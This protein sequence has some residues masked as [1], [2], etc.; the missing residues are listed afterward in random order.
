V[1]TTEQARTKP[2]L[3]PSAPVHSNLLQLKC[4]CG[5]APGVDGM[6][7]ECREKQLQ[8]NAFGEVERDPASNSARESLHSPGEPPDPETRALMGPRSGHDFSRIQVHSP[9]PTGIQP[10]LQVSTPNDRYEQEANRVADQ[11]IRMLAPPQRQLQPAEEEDL[12]ES[13]STVQRRAAG[14]TGGGEAPPIIQEVLSSPG[15]PLDPSTRQFME[16]RFGHDFSQ[17]RVHADKRA[18][19]SAQAVNAR[20]YAVGRNVVFGQGEYVPGNSESQS[21]LA[22]EL[23]HIALNH[24]GVRCI[25]DWQIEAQEEARERRRREREA[26]ARRHAEWEA[27]VGRQFGPELSS[28]ALTI[29][30]ERERLGLALT[31]QRAAAFD[32]VASGQGWLQIAL[33]EQG[34]SG[35][36]VLE[37]KER[38]AEALVAAELLRASSSADEVTTDVRIHALETIPA[39][40]RDIGILA[41]A[42]EQAH[43]AH[44]QS[45]NDKLSIQYERQ[46]E[47][48]EAGQRMDRMAYGPRGEPGEAAFRA[49]LAL[50][51]GSPPAEPKYLSEPPAISGSIPAASARVDTAETIADWTKVA[52]DLRR[53]DA[54]L[55]E[56]LVASLE[57]SSEV[58]QNIEYLTQLEGRLT[59]L[60]GK[61]PVA[62]RIPAVFYPEDQ[63]T[64]QTTAEGQ[65]QTRP[66]SIPWQFYLINTGVPTRDQPARSGGEWILKDLTSSQGFENKAPASDRDSAMLQQGAV[67]DPPI[68][69]F[70]KLN[71]RIRF[72]NGRIYFTLPSGQSYVLRTTEPWSLS[73]FLAAMGITLAAIAITA[74]VVATGGAAAPAAIAFYAGLG[75]AAAGA[76]STLAEMNERRQHGILTSADVDRAMIQIGIDLVGALSLGLGRLVTAPGAIARFGS[77]F[78]V[79]SRV[80]QAARVANV[81]GDVYQTLTVTDS[82]LDAFNA[83]ENQ[84]GLTDEQRDRM[85]GQLVRRAI[86]TGAILTVAI[87]GDIDEI[88][89][90]QTLRVSSVDPDGAIVVHGRGTA[91][92]GEADAPRARASP[93][94]PGPGRAPHA[95]VDGP[96]H[97]NAQQAGSGL[98]VG[99]QSHVVG[100][101]G[102]GR[103]RDFYFCSDLC[104]PIADHLRTI[105]AVLPRNHP[106]RPAVQDILVR[107]R[108]AGRQLKNGQLSQ[109]GADAVARE[110]SDRIERLSRD[111]QHFA[112]LMNTDPALLATQPH[113]I[114]QRL[115]DA[116]EDQAAHLTEQSA[117]QE[118]SRGSS[119]GRAPLEPRAPRSPIETDILGGIGMSDVA[120]AS[121]GQQPFRFDV[122]NF[123]HTYAEVLVPSLPRGLNKEVSLTLPDGSVRRADRVRFVYDS[124]GD[125]IGAHVYE[126]KPDVGDHV[127][128]GKIQVQDYVAGLRAE[129]ES[130]LRAK[131]KPVPTS[132]PDGGPLF[133]GHVLTYDRNKM[134]AV[135]R[136]LRASRKD[137]ANMR[138]LEAI[139]RQVFE[140]T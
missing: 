13:R 45:T 131:G 25:T 115:R 87:R 94:A 3:Q 29:S 22:H 6:C 31:G 52:D 135:L 64:T 76:G 72:P 19:E 130:V 126:I 67:V 84:P 74:G 103:R 24:S 107:A 68:E 54:G 42:I 14:G 85:R 40:Y 134:R 104:A 39:F 12:L 20:A 111:S 5:G 16:S 125:R 57:Q 53:L 89:S 47:A 63:T 46:L 8:R 136:A 62:F 118:A 59:E 86:L 48:Y 137:V 70:S 33:Q 1:N 110:L 140:G 121:R 88:R 66:V 133:S 15:R 124:D 58:R 119:R 2:A 93:G 81:A 120:R 80:T 127:A 43:R 96:V 105:L 18:V 75:A 23:A 132:A 102:A 51:R 98:Q 128:R 49:G 60:E 50:S 55:S 7:G 97:A 78:V 100:V 108:R 26:A 4:A 21:L 101:G 65:T 83:I 77:R 61:H 112:A 38:W 129:I 37:V 41:P 106:F 123:S 92:H 114:R 27:G 117:R 113:A 17:V 90:G 11:V 139:A 69:M 79:I 9:V 28:Q 99:P 71:S 122:G 116:L 34:Y 91:A 36:T 32:A 10:K 109:Q 73:D 56:L 35:P 30:A 44:I 82:F 138:E 95:E